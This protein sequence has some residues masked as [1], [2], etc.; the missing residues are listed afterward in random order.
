MGKS[1]SFYKMQHLGNDFI[2]FWL[3]DLLADY[4]HL[5]T[6]DLSQWQSIAR[7]L[8]Q[9]KFGVGAD[10]VILLLDLD[11]IE[12][13]N[14][15]ALATLFATEYKAKY[16]FNLI[17][18]DGSIAEVSGNGLICSSKVILDKTPDSGSDPSNIMPFNILTSNRVIEIGVNTQGKFKVNLAIPEFDENFTAELMPI[19][20]QQFDDYK[21]LYQFNCLSVTPVNTGNPHCVIELGD[22]NLKDSRQFQ[23][24]A[25][26]GE[27][28]QRLSIFPQGVNVEFVSILNKSEIA[29]YVVERGCGP[30]LACGSGACASCAAMLKIHPLVSPVTVSMPG[31][32]VQVDWA[33]QADSHVCLIGYPQTVFLGSVDISCLQSTKC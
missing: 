2:V 17:N 11:L 16:G 24:L 9:S 28:I 15:K 19:I 3:T 32:Q 6:A 22:L 23:V 7:Q 27:S 26:I 21:S 10:G 30:T 29:L 20:N 13:H 33:K 12:K 31:G 1:I 25:Q 4:K 14:L 5:F 18:K 8:C